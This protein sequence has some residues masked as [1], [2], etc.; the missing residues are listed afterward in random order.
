M[1]PCRVSGIVVHYDSKHKEPPTDSRIV[2]RGHGGGGAR[3][4][5]R[6][7]SRVTRVSRSHPHASPSALLS[8]TAE[9]SAAS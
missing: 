2:A 9:G 5:M 7:C 6:A 8:A 1:P 3:M 4:G